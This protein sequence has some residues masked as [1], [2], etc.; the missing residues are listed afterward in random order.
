MR[1]HD[2]VP[3][4]VTSLLDN[5]DKVRVVLVGVTSRI[6]ERTILLMF[7]GIILKILRLRIPLY[8][9]KI[10]VLFRPLLL[11]ASYTVKK[12]ND[13]PVPSRDVTNQTLP[14]RI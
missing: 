3:A 6:H 7:L 9:V 2:A 1:S 13:F 5:L 10:T 12:G 11:T 8:N 14:G 4:D